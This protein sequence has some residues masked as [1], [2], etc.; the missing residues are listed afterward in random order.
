M[1]NLALLGAWARALRLIHAEALL[2]PLLAQRVAVVEQDF[3]LGYV[4]QIPKVEFVLAPKAAPG[5]V[6]RILL[7]LRRQ[8]KHRLKWG[9]GVVHARA[10]VSR[11]APS[12]ILGVGETPAAQD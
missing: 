4:G 12:S 8:R 2:H 11:S 10:R 9:N 7:I 5:P 1:A 3:V 6:L